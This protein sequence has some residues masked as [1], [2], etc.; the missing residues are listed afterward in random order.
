MK[1]RTC[2]A[3][4]AL[5]VPAVVLAA[6]CGLD[7]VGTLG[8]AAPGTDDGGSSGDGPRDDATTADGDVRVDASGIDGDVAD[9]TLDQAVAD[10]AP[11]VL[12]SP[13]CPSGQLRCGGTCVSATDCT[14][15]AS[16]KIVCR[17]LRECLTTCATCTDLARAPV[18]I[19]CVA[20]D[21]SQANPIGTCEPNATST[22]CLSGD[23][24]T[25]HNGGPGK[26]CD[27]SGTQ[28][29]NCVVEEQTCRNVAS[30][31][32]CSTCGELG[33]ATN[34]KTCKNGKT[35]NT[36]LSPPSCQ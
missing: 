23:Y 28:V 16:G 32:Y 6:A 11:D 36:A 12:L 2:V 15:C 27:C 29:S 35:C 25:A 31:D 5:F 22:F 9:A 20:C 24:S 30:T 7:S 18:P 13:A 1:R 17:A 26:Q 10:A 19:E 8:A 3:L 14:A 34:G 4:V 33:G 21:T